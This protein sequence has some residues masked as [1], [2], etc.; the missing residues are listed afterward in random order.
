MVLQNVPP[1]KAV[2]EAH[3]ELEKAVAEMKARSKR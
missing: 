1:E 3:A 2:A